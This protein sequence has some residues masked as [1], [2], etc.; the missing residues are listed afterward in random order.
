MQQRVPS[1]MELL[2]IDKTMPDKE[3]TCRDKR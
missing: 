3:Y 2:F 1:Y